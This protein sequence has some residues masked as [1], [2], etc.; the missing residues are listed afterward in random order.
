MSSKKKNKQK[1]ASR[2]VA[3][4]LSPSRPVTMSQIGNAIAVGTQQ[5]PTRSDY[6]GIEGPE[7][8]GYARALRIEPVFKAATRFLV[9]SMLSSLGPYT[10]QDQRCQ[11]FIRE[12]FDQMSGNL[13]RVLGDMM[14]SALWSGKAVSEMLFSVK[15]G[16]WW[17]TDVVNYHPKTIALVP[18]RRGILTDGKTNTIPGTTYPATGVWQQIPSTLRTNYGESTRNS[19][20]DYVRIPLAKCII[21]KHDAFHNSIHGQSLF[22]PAW[23]FY[24]MKWN[25]LDSWMVTSEKYGSPTVAVVVPSGITMNMVSDG[26]GGT[27]PE[28][29]AEA[30]VRVLSNLKASDGMVFEAPPGQNTQEYKIQTVTTG[31]NFG[32]SYLQTVRTMDYQM[33]MAMGIPPLLFLEHSGGLG[34]GEISQ[35]Q[36]DMFKQTLVSLYM[37]F[38]EP[39]L[40][41]CIGRILRWNFGVTDPGEFTFK[42]TDP[43]SAARIMA[44][45]KDALMSGLIDV[46]FEKD[47]QHARSLIDWEPAEGEH[48]QALLKGNKKLMEGIRNPE[49]TKMSIAKLQTGT[50]KEIATLGHDH[51]SGENQKDREHEVSQAEKDRKLE[52]QKVQND[53]DMKMQTATHQHKENLAAIKQGLVAQ[54]PQAPSA[55]SAPKVKKPTK[56]AS[57]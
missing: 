21:I 52:K 27:R 33:L 8:E 22:A 26:N 14:Y 16:L 36:A 49:A 54:P 11:R 17:L 46:S 44:T 41:Q 29:T 28:T 25:S 51:E 4:T 32:D 12:M 6:R 53:H 1:S 34:A 30:A 39:F 40:E 5:D 47:L 24:E 13:Y 31:N 37:E 45:T 56:P 42:P 15:N 9:L 48:L 3:P 35:T 2:N 10:H 23:I 7:L 55:P 38:V 19:H 43:G 50:Q 20:R 57:Q 18:D